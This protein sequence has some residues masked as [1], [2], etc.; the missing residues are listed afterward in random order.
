MK[1]GQTKKLGKFPS[2]YVKSSIYTKCF[3]T[4]EPFGVTSQFFLFH[5]KVQRDKFHKEYERT[6]RKSIKIIFLAKSG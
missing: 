1:R 2:E 5:P 3:R 4:L 6:K